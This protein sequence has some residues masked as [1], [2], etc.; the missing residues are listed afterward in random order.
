[1]FGKRKC[2]SCGEKV[3]ESYNFCPYCRNPLSNSSDQKDFGMLG[4]NDFPDFASQGEIRLP[5]GINAIFNSLLKSLNKQVNEFE[6]MGQEPKK[7]GIKKRGIGI[8]IHTSLNKAPE[9]RVTSYGDEK[10]PQKI[11]EQQE[12]LELPTTNSKKFSGLPKEEPKTNIRRF[13]DK[14]VYEINLPG[15]KSIDDVS[16]SQLESSI[17]VKALGKEKV[18]QKIIPINLPIR[19]YNFSN[20]KLVLELEDSE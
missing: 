6:R 7:Q 13:S 8:S 19:N 11:E 4:K 3:N 9:I 20:K 12:K 5:M 17:E 1:M 14:V 10:K 18:Y 2:R 15:V 16:I